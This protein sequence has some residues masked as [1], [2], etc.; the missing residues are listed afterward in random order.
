MKTIL[1]LFLIL[2]SNTNAQ[3]S[4]NK[5]YFYAKEYNS[6]KTLY[7]TKEFLMKN[8]LITTTEAISFE[9]DPLVSANS[10]ELT[11]ISYN[12][13]DL[14]KSG[15]IFGFWGNYVTDAGLVYQGYKFY[16]FEQQEAEELASIIDKTMELNRSYLLQDVNNNNVMIKYK[17]LEFLFYVE[18]VT[19]IRVFW[20]GFDAEWNYSEF[21]KSIK[22]M[23]KKLE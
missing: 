20:D 13:T 23:G 21:K 11:T 18:G 10:G 22:R 12:C 7:L 14:K 3:L 5:G 16:N 8:V 6:A 4:I 2:S 17:E 9:I 15:L 1:F 19:K